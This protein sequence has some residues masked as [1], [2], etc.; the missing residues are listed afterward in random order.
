MSFLVC[1]KIGLALL[2][3]VGLCPLYQKNP[4]ILPKG[5]V[6]GSPGIASVGGFFVGGRMELGV[7]APL[8]PGFKNRQENQA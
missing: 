3:M 7:G 8:F 1:L 6:G 2:W 5:S 4:S